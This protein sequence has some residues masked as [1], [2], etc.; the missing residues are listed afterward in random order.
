MRM[1]MLLTE[2]IITWSM[3]HL[4]SAAVLM[5]LQIIS[6]DDKVQFGTILEIYFTGTSTKKLPAALLPLCSGTATG[7]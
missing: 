5:N 3:M 2:T 4:P 7:F 1:V 6:E